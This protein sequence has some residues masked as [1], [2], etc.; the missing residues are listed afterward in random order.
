[1]YI[2]AMEFKRSGLEPPARRPG[3]TRFLTDFEAVL[4]CQY[5]TASCLWTEKNYEYTNC[6]ELQ[7]SRDQHTITH[8]PPPRPDHPSA[9]LTSALSFPHARWS[10]CTSSGRRQCAARVPTPMLSTCR[11]RQTIVERAITYKR[12][13]VSNTRLTGL[14][15][16]HINA[17]R[18]KGSPG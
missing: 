5:D 3:L 7:V 14:K 9:S 18:A 17:Y 4:L 16:Q 1:M 13:R 15:Q 10:R 12:Y 8:Q 11:R 2:L 6:P